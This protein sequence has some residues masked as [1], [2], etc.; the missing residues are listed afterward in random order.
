MIKKLLVWWPDG[1]LSAA[2][3]V[4][5]GMVLA[6]AP[7]LFLFMIARAFLWQWALLFLLIA[8][9]N[10]PGRR[11]WSVGASVIA[12][13][14]VFHPTWITEAPTERSSTN[15]LVVAQMNVLQTNDE[16]AAVVAAALSTGAD[17]ISFQEVDTVWAR[18]LVEGLGRAYPYRVIRSASDLYGIAAFSKLPFEHAMVLDLLGHPMLDLTIVPSGGSLRC[19]FVHASSPGTLNSFRERNAQLDRSVN[20]VNASELPL[21]LVGDLNTVSWDQAFKRL[22][23]H[24]D[25]AELAE[26]I[27]GTWPAMAGFGCIPLDHVLA[28][29][30]L[31]VSS[32]TPFSIPGSDH[33]GLVA[34]IHPR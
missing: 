34:V 5:V 17:L 12:A 8:C 20:M 4:L 27:H 11:W 10:I 3:L 30:E 6:L 13:I 15:V 31:A 32:V 29:P 33:L 14:L 28:T 22:C 1:P 18:V 26:G 16:H 9:W 24:T 23:M 25:L 21:L 19:L 7:D 2:A